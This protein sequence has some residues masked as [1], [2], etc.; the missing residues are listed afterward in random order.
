[1]Y[2]SSQDI[3]IEFVVVETK[4]I[5]GSNA[6][7]MLKRHSASAR[8]GLWEANAEHSHFSIR[9][10]YMFPIS[11]CGEESDLG[12]CTTS[13]PSKK[14]CCVVADQQTC[15]AAKFVGICKCAVAFCLQVP[16]LCT[17]L[18]PTLLYILKLGRYCKFARKHK[19][20]RC[21]PITAG[22]FCVFSAECFFHIYTLYIF[23]DNGIRKS[24][25][26]SSSLRKY[27]NSTKT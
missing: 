1:V 22:I 12:L 3:F 25:L 9:I 8:A 10:W 17:D 26:G 13:I 18:D 24:L 15:L 6:N 7:V 5:V 16:K 19:I 14:C 20:H 27:P 2:S 4:Q 21:T 23:F 11:K